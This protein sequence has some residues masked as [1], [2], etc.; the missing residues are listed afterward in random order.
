MGC[1][2]QEALIMD[3]FELFAPAC[4]HVLIRFFPFL[5]DSTTVA[6]ASKLSLYL[7]FYPCLMYTEPRYD[8]VW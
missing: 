2:A 6:S 4:N 8:V 7:P 1:M 3:M 5:I